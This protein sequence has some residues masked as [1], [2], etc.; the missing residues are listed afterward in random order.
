MGPGCDGHTLQCVP[1]RL[2]PNSN[3]RRRVVV[4]GGG[5]AGLEALIGLRT[6]AG[7]RVELELISPEQTFN[8]RPLIVAAAFGSRPSSSIEIRDVARTVGAACT[9]DAIRSSRSRAP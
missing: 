2:H 5:V 3:G 8:Y 4:V 6:L 7:Q 9:T 1:S